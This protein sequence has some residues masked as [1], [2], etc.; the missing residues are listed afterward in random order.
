MRIFVIADIHGNLPALEAVL[1]DMERFKPRYDPRNPQADR[2]ICLGD[3]IGYYA[4]PNEVMDRIWD[5]GCAVLIGNHEINIQEALLAPDDLTWQWGMNPQA[6]WAFRWTA[7][8]LNAVNRERLRQLMEARSYVAEDLPHRII[9]S[10][11]TPYLP[12]MMHYITCAEE[13][14]W[15][16]F[17]LPDLQFFQL[18][19]VGHLHVSQM[20]YCRAQNPEL[21]EQVQGGRVLF[22]EP[23]QPMPAEAAMTP[24]L[25]ELLVCERSGECYEKTWPL[26]PDARVLASVPSVG[27]PRDGVP[28]A[29]YVVIDTSARTLTMVRVNYDIAAV[30]QA[31][32]KLPGCPDIL[33]QRLVVGR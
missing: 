15:Q 27:Q 33:I 6:V 9:F 17:R 29:G 2:L 22:R 25:R 8:N 11:A 28:C 19:V 16:F 1:G 12:E 3:V 26:P 5:L 24:A 23:D 18:A 21:F 14:W 31:M 7:E 32:S 30:V 10:H 13:A 20:Y 4:Y